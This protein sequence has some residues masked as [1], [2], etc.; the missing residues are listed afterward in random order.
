MSLEGGNSEVQGSHRP[1]VGGAIS[2]RHKQEALR[3]PRTPHSSCPETP[4]DPA[5]RRKQDPGLSP[6]AGFLSTQEVS[7]VRSPPPCIPSEARPHIF[8][9]GRGRARGLGKHIKGK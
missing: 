5:G 7:N 9:S 8:R 4:K 2:Q 3:C 6:D 1:K